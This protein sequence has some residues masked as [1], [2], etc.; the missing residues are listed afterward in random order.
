T[1]TPLPFGAGLHE[2]WRGR[3]RGYRGPAP[4][5]EPIP[6][7][8]PD[9]VPDGGRF[10]SGLYTNHAGTRSYKLYI[11]SGYHGK[12]LPLVVMLHG[13]TQNPDDFAAGTRMNVLAEE[14]RC[15]V[16]YPAQ[17]HA[18][19]GSKCWNWFEPADQ[20]RDRGEP[21]IIAG[22]TRQII[23]SHRVD[24]RRIYV[25]GLSAGGAMAL[26]MTMTYPDLYAAVG[27]HSGLPYGV[28]QDLPSAFTAMRCG[29]GAS[30][31]RH[32]ACAPVPA[33]VFHGDRDTTVH[34]CNGNRVVAQCAPSRA[35]RGEP[36]EGGPARRV[37]VERGQVPH[38]HAYTRT[39]RH[40]ASGQPV[41]E[42]WLV[43]GAGHA[44]SGGNCRGSYT[45]SK[46]PDASQEMLRFFYDHPQGGH[47]HRSKTHR[48]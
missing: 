28:A 44:W 41:V 33:I 5:S 12:P 27:I 26:T 37:S 47:R 46:G 30:T 17:S 16:A 3:W 18:A 1:A 9:I 22:L 29:E 42:H 34:P 10:T 7:R 36:P 21:S 4:W 32:T 19:N 2:Q 35:R 24:A 23:D 14:H 43:H 48:S 6:D 8:A 40:D 15:F 20:Q 11:P 39:T 31:R 38:G 45:D 13:C 25:A